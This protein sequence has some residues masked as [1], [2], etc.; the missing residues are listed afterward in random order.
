MRKDQVSFTQ[1]W[2][3]ICG[4]LVTMAFHT[5]PSGAALATS[6]A[7]PWAILVSGGLALLMFW[8]VASALAQLPGK[9]LS[10]LALT[11]G[12][13]ALAIA[14]ALLLGGLFVISAG[15]GV[16]Q[17]SEMVVTAL[18]PHTPQTFAMVSLV[19]TAA[20]GAS[21]TPAVALWIGSLYN[22]P[23]LISILLLLAGNLG[24]GQFRNLVPL[25]GH[26]LL[27]TGLELLPLTSYAA[28]LAY[29]AIF[30]SLLPS[31]GKLVRASVYA[32]G[33]A[34]VI[35]SL[36]ILLY[37]MVFPLP[38]GLDVQFPLFEMSRLVQGGRYFER[39]DALW[40]IFWTFGAAGRLTES[41]MATALLFKN[42]FHLPNHR[43]AVLPLTMA[44]LAVGLFPSNQVGAVEAEIYGLRRWGFLVAL[45]LPLLI[46]LL[47]RV[48]A[49][50]KGGRHA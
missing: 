3:T 41:L 8:P 38:G 18:Y 11:A 22:W 10:D 49:R 17:V 21:M 23:M 32:L 30:C 33:V 31:P 44:V 42:A 34:V 15:L 5:L 25:T 27:P 28:P 35:W 48:R 1:L 6:T 37:L 7:A 4:A 12:G 24:W 50:Q 39:I 9:N 16:R 20:L 40:L 19:T 29:M 36:V 43:G 2:T 14:T 26:G 13:R 47:A 46:A 45:G